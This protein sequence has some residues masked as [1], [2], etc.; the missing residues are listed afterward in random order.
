MARPTIYR[1]PCPVVE[2]P[3]NERVNERLGATPARPTERGGSA[4]TMYNHPRQ[5]ASAKKKWR[6]PTGDP[7]LH[8]RH[9]FDNVAVGQWPAT[10]PQ[11]VALAGAQYRSNAL[12]RSFAISP[13]LRPSIW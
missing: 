4:G 3:G 2:F 8:V 13:A 6:G 7:L 11:T 1:T 9:L 12:V 10:K 5:S